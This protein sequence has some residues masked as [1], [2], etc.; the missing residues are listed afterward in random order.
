MGRADAA[1][2]VALRVAKALT[3]S[4]AFVVLMSCVAHGF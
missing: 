2:M 1:Q 3:T 4:G